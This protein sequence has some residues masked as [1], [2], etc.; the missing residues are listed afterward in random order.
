LWEALRR[1]ESAQ[2]IAVIY[3]T[4]RATPEWRYF[5]NSSTSRS[6]NASQRAT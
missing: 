4:A 6:R 5:V 3:V 1:Y 2:P